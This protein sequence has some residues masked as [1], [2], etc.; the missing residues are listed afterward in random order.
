MNKTNFLSS[1]SFYF[2]RGENSKQVYNILG[3]DRGLTEENKLE[4]GEERVTEGVGFAVIYKVLINA[5]KWRKTENGK[6]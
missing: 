5:K 1:W 4:Q 3:G 6:V 2:R